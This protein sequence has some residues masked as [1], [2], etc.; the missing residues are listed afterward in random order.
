[1]K[2]TLICLFWQSTMLCN[3]RAVS[4]LWPRHFLVWIEEEMGSLPWYSEVVERTRGQ[5][6]ERTN[7]G[8]NEGRRLRRIVQNASFSV[9]EG[10][11]GKVLR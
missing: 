7:A 11:K 3:M 5:V 1:M 9:A 2:I 8:A 4:C 10:K 6:A